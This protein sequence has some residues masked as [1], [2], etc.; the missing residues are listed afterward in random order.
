[1]KS[2]P[3]RPSPLCLIE[4]DALMGESLAARFRLEGFAVDWW[5]D[6][7]S[8]QQALTER[9]YGV[10]VSDIRLPD[11][12][13]GELFL[14]LAGRGQ[15]L[16]PFVFMTGFGSID[17]AVELLKA[18]A[19]DYVTKPFDADVLVAKVRELVDGYG[20]AS[21]HDGGDELGI[22]APMRRIA[23]SLPRLAQQA[24]T[25][26]LCGESGVGKEHVAALFHRLSDTGAGPFVAVN[27]GAIPEP[28][29][30]AELFG[31]ERGAF[32]GAVKAKRGYFEHAHGGTLFLDEVG[33]MP[34]AMQVKLLRVLQEQRVRRLGGEADVDVRFR[35]V[36]ATH[37]DLKAMVEAG[38]FR[39]DLFY[40]IDVIHLRIPPLRERRED[41]RW[42]VRR[43]VE[44]FN[45]AHPQSRRRLDPRTEQA[46]SAYAWP[47][48]VRELKH[49]VERACILSPG[50]LLDAEAFFGDG[51]QA[52]PERQAP[53]ARLVEY[54]MDCERQYLRIVLDQHDWHM[55]R[56][57]EALGISRK[58]LWDKLRRLGIRPVTLGDDGLDL[59]GSPSISH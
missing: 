41:I 47:G 9:R 30:E 35:L 51:T 17:R 1:M 3:A 6:G 7:A 5:R 8:A 22:S 21:E 15:P 19:A 37:R 27:C 46:L 34:P 49:A 55:T 45:Q 36:C 16:P 57:A 20:A 4:D 2:A 52:E 44:A 40:R 13:G 31:F 39:E 14:E 26:L 43:F 12:N 58:S 56:S 25:L 23:E 53:S 42:F 29:L 48:N 32:T 11:R 18:G 50:P 10:V 54:L 28:L 59:S 24:Q 38:Q 33:D